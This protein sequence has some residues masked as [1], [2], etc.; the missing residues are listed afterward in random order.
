MIS[1]H[2]IYALTNCEILKWKKRLIVENMIFNNEK[3]I[4][5]YKNFKIKIIIDDIVYPHT[6][7]TEI[8][9]NDVIIKKHF[10][11]LFYNYSD[12]YSKKLYELLN[13]RN[14]QDRYIVPNSIEYISNPLKKRAVKIKLLK[15]ELSIIG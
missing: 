9:Y 8:Y 11:S 5:I 12:I 1:S 14:I 4:C 6:Y 10:Y 15:N 3:Y 13:T 7:K 2:F